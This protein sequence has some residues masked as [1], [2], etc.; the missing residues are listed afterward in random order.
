M[1]KNYKT[2]FRLTGFLAVFG[3][4]MAIIGFALL[5]RFFGYPEIIREEPKVI[6]EKLYAERH[7][8][9]YLYYIGIGIAGICLLFFSMLLKKIF[10][11]YGEDLWAY[12]GCFCGM[13][14]G[15]LLYAGIIRYTFLFPFL[16]EQ[17]VKGTYDA[18]TIDLV[19]ASFNTYVGDSIAEHVQFTFTSLMLLFF[20]IA[21]LKTNI[22]NKWIGYFGIVTSVVLIYGNTEFFGMPGAF[23]FNRIGGDMI[24]LWLLAVGLNLLF[25]REFPDQVLKE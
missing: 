23:T 10:S 18:K 25:K 16:A 8:V 6:L 7:I 4:L 11:I 3:G 14:S 21:I 5:S 22:I 24:A 15:L 20:G 12:M 2:L 1:M 17:R 9:P 19:F 13:I